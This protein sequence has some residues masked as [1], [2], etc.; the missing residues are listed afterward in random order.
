MRSAPQRRP[1][2]PPRLAFVD[3]IR[4][5]PFPGIM[6]VVVSSIR[7]ATQSFKFVYYKNWKIIK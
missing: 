1:T 4:P 3:M 7:L 6:R 5:T 2:T